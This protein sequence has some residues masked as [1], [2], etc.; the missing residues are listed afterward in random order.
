MFRNLAKSLNFI[1][2]SFILLGLS[3]FAS[4]DKAIAADFSRS[5]GRAASASIFGVYAMVAPCKRAPNDNEPKPTAFI[6]SDVLRVNDNGGVNW[7]SP[8]NE[9]QDTIND[10]R[11][12]AKILRYGPEDVPE[13]QKEPILR[14]VCSGSGGFARNDVYLDD[15]ISNIGGSLYYDPNPSL[16]RI[17]PQIPPAIPSPPAEEPR[18]CISTPGPAK[19]PVCKS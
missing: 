13:E 18:N 15:N 9:N 1:S 10:N 5:C 16:G 3:S 19:T 8:S 11:C 14:V 17:Q 6:L 12:P 2:S 4:S 7:R